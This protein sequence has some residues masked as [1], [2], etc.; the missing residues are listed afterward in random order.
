MVF[1]K[2]LDSVKMIT[3]RKIFYKNIASVSTSVAGLLLTWNGAHAA[4]I[5]FLANRITMGFTRIRPESIKKIR[6]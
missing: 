2:G 5:G 3:N 4:L 6:K 1:R